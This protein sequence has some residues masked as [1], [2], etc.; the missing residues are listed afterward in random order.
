MNKNPFILCYVSHPEAWF[1]TNDLSKQWG[2]DWNDIPYEYNAGSPYSPCWHRKENINKEEPLC[3]CNSCK[4]EWTD[5]IPNWEIVKINYT[6][7]F[8]TPD[9]EYYNSP[10]SVEMINKKI[11]PWLQP[12]KYSSIQKQIFAGTRIDK[13]IKLIYKSGGYIGF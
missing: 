10:Y 1:T 6:A 12:L 8:F 2:D 4:Q 13:F 11:I 5:N 9:H 3:Q 7:P